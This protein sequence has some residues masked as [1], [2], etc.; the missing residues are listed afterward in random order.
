MDRQKIVLS[1][2][3]TTSGG[4]WRC[5]SA[6]GPC[7]ARPKSDLTMATV[8]PIHLRFHVLYSYHSYQKV[9]T[10]NPVRALHATHSSFAFSMRLY[11]EILP[12]PQGAASLLA[13]HATSF[14]R[15]PAVV[16]MVMA[17]GP[18]QSFSEVWHLIEQ[19]YMTNYLHPEQ[20]RLVYFECGAICFQT[21]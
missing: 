14:R 2:E 1:M 5:P 6:H 10:N 17:F 4:P 19:R 8:P 13:A 3:Y 18:E 7:E 15:V 9:F 21:C 20:R 12:L 16:K 11:V